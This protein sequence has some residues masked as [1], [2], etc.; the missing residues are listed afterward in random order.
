MPEMR[1]QVEEV[2]ARSSAPRT[3][4]NM[5]KCFHSGCLVTKEKRCGG[6]D[7][8]DM[9]SRL[10]GFGESRKWRKAPNLRLRQKQGKLGKSEALKG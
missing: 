2:R 6:G 10:K 7:N 4:G 8:V 1:A 9:G 3:G 5:R